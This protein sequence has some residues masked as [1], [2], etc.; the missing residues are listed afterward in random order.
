MFCVWIAHSIHST[1]V[2]W[3]GML[4]ICS[5]SRKIS[6]VACRMK[7]FYI[8][9]MDPFFLFNFKPSPRDWLVK[10]WNCNREKRSSKNLLLKWDKLWWEYKECRAD[11]YQ[12]DKTIYDFD[13][14]Y[15]WSIQ[16]IRWYLCIGIFWIITTWKRKEKCLNKTVEIYQDHDDDGRTLLVNSCREG[17]TIRR[18][19]QK[20]WTC[21]CVFRVCRDSDKT[22]VS[23]SNKTKIC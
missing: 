20:Y 17:D 15:I 16:A 5:K 10:S 21:V 12:F 6:V 2:L 19:S 8:F 23:I 1:P 14:F 9:Y 13:P 11:I 18:H 7:C 22:H 3:Y 4:D